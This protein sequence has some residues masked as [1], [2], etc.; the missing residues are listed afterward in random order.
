MENGLILIL[1][2]HVNFILGAIVHGNVLRHISK[3]SLHI[4]TEYTMANIISVTSGLLVGTSAGLSNHYARLPISLCPLSSPLLYWYRR[5]IHWAVSLSVRSLCPPLLESIGLPL[6]ES[7]RS[8][9]KLTARFADYVPINQIVGVLTDEDSYLPNLQIYDAQTKYFSVFIFTQS[10]MQCF[11]FLHIPKI[12]KPFC[13]CILGTMVVMG[14]VNEIPHWNM[15][16]SKSYFI[17]YLFCFIMH[18]KY[19]Q[20]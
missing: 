1:V 5:T 18:Y 2:G 6:S 19:T 7:R 10:I 8:M 11:F 3:P 4:T 13:L 15:N 16:I 14:D 9:N 17:E 12:C 20:I